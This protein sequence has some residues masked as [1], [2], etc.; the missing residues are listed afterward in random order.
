MTAK[1]IHLVS[2]AQCGAECRCAEP[3]PDACGSRIC[4]AP[5]RIALRA[6]H[7]DRAMSGNFI[8]TEAKLIGFSAA[9]PG[10]TAA[11]SAAVQ[12]RDPTAGSRTCSAPLRVALRAGH[13]DRAMGGNF[14][15][16]EAK[17]PRPTTAFPGRA[18]ARSAAV[19][20]RD[21]TPGS[22]ICSAPLRVALRAGHGDRVMGG[23][24]ISTKAKLIGLP[25]PTAAFPGRTAARSAAVQNRDPT[26][27]GPASAVHHCVSPRAWDTGIER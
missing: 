10:R 18:A 3:G 15:S 5:L 17:L 13:G 22:R 23:N 4:S 26:P 6:G 1:Q 2:R 8:S 19:Q 14:I 12:N 11:R 9:F 20:N 21:P 25:R 24:F 16:I 27:V 7:G